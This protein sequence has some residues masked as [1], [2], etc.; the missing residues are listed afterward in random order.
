METNHSGTALRWTYVWCE[1]AND[2]GNQDAHAT[3]NGA[4]DAGYHSRIIRA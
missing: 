1:N 4:S 3:G 2:D